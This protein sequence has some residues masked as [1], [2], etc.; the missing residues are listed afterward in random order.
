[1]F[2]RFIDWYQP[3]WTITNDNISVGHAIIICLA[4]SAWCFALVFL[5]DVNLAQPAIDLQKPLAELVELK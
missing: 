3:Q 4:V 1:M 2:K 5:D